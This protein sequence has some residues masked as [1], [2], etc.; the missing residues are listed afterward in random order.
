MCLSLQKEITWASVCWQQLWCNNCKWS[1]SLVFPACNV[2]PSFSHSREQ[3]STIKGINSPEPP[4][5]LNST[6]P[7]VQSIAN[8]SNMSTTSSPRTNRYIIILTLN[9]GTQCA[10]LPSFTQNSTLSQ[11]HCMYTPRHSY[12]YRGSFTRSGE[13]WGAEIGQAGARAGQLVLGL[14]TGSLWNYL[15][16]QC[17]LLTDWCLVTVMVGMVELSAWALT[18]PRIWTQEDRKAEQRPFSNPQTL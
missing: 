4:A 16:S 9:T 2:Q 11:G 14:L 3:W 8:N 12:K 7:T 15:S 18:V 1:A 5:N 17:S 10:V 6:W 13:V